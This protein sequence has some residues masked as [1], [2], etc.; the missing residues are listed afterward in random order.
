MEKNSKYNMNGENRSGTF[1]KNSHDNMA[2]G[3]YE[4]IKAKDLRIPEDISVVGYDDMKT[5]FFM[6]QEWQLPC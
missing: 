2:I 1:G 5:V 6:D 3:V 4:A